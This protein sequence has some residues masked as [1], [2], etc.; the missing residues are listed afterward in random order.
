MPTQ[1]APAK[2]SL[3]FDKRILMEKRGPLPVWAWLAIGLGLLLVVLWWRRRNTNAE[4]TEAA[5]GFYRDELPGDQG[6]PPIF[7]V[8]PA[9]PPAVNINNPITVPAAP[10]GAG[11]PPPAGPPPAPP[12]RAEIDPGV[13]VYGWVDKLNE[14]YPGLKL[15][16]GKLDLWNPG[17][18]DKS[19]LAWEPIAG[20]NYKLPRNLVKRELRIR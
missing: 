17:W 14:K 2:A 5:A 11:A 10:P 9:T 18:R 4:A 3:S 1:A 19:K 20:Q 16:F 6:A 12:E 8:P 15:D 13:N 7:I